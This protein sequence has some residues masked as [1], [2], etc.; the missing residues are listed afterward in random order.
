VAHQHD[1]LLIDVPKPSRPLDG[2]KDVTEAPGPT[3][4]WITYASILDVPGCDPA[5]AERLTEVTRVD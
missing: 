2:Q 3:T 1:F 5:L 4:S